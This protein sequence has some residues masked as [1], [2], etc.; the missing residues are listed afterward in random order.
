MLFGLGIGSFKEGRW[1]SC[2]ETEKETQIRVLK[3]R[4]LG[5]STHAFDRELGGG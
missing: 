4:G 5:F 2:R 1:F 3:L